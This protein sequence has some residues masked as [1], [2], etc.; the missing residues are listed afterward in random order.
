MSD[1][2]LGQVM[3]TG[4]NFPPK[5][6]AQCNGQLLPIM[7]NTA[8]F[9]L[10]GTFYGGN[11][12]ANF[13]L[14]DLRGRTPIHYDDAMG[15]HVSIGQ[16]GGVENVTLLLNEL[17]QHTHALQATT[18]TGTTRIPKGNA[19]AHSASTG[20][21]AAA[22]STVSLLQQSVSRAG[23]TQA[24]SNMQPYTTLNF[25]IALVGVYPSRG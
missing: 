4:F 23:N 9:S 16:Q 12:A 22:Q 18:A 8:L 11:G 20:I 13:A 7:Q 25:C 17:P 1:F 5:G 21:Y 19:L 3:M 24:H 2:F 14:P 6:F 10:L 15:S